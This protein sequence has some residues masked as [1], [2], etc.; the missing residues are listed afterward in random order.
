MVINNLSLNAVV[1]IVTTNF[2]Q[3]PPSGGVRLG[4]AVA[5]RG[6]YAMLAE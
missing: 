5:G 3:F 1:G 6:L 2:F 4:S